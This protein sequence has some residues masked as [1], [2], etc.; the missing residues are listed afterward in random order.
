MTERTQNLVS[1]ALFIA[2]GILLPVLFHAFG[3]GS[4]FLPM[5]WPVAA[6]GFFVPISFSLYVGILTPLLSYMTTGMPPPPILYRMML[7]LGFLGSLTGLLYQKTRWGIFW[8]VLVSFFFTQG[9]GFL[10]AFAIAPILGL[11]PQFY[12]LISRIKIIPGMVCMGIFIPFILRRIKNE[13]A[14]KSR[15]RMA[16]SH[17]DYF[18]RLAPEWNGKVKDDPI[19]K[20]YLMRFGVSAGDR[21]VDIGAG[22]GRMAKHL[23]G[24]VGKNGCVVAEDISDRMLKEGKRLLQNPH[25]HW[26]CDDVMS[27]AFKE[28]SFD[29]VLCFSAFPHFPDPTVALKEMHRVLRPGGKLLIL[30]T[31]SSE[32]LNEFHASLENTVCKDVLPA[33]KNVKPLLKQAGFAPGKTTEK[34]DLYWVEGWKPL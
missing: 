27:L 34:D 24:L 8:I 20:E 12:A 11:P 3:L 1:S 14:F 32:R 33:I 25:L 23:I 10:G 28:A 30:H 22:T 9:I 13:P 6:C 2:L 21:I 26:V 7:E 4:V 19:L 15:K 31:C 16:Q 5:F 29:K 17:R 18:N